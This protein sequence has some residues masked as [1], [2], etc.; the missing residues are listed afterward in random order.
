MNTEQT[1]PNLIHKI[2]LILGDWSGDGHEKTSSFHIMSSLPKEKIID[3]YDR[4]V[5]ILKF[6]ITSCCEEYED[7]S[8]PEEGQ[9]VLKKN[10]PKLFKSIDPEWLVKDDFVKIYL[11]MVAVGD[12][13]FVFAHQEPNDSINLGGYGLFC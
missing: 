13:T 5:K 9:E 11:A 2:E 7:H 10:F 6:D 4:A 3:A 1:N 12:P 8:L